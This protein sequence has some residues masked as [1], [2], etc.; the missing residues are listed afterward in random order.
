MVR[1]PRVVPLFVALP[2]EDF[3]AVERLT[4]P[5]P[6][7]LMEGDVGRAGGEAGVEGVWLRGV[8]VRWPS[9]R[10]R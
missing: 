2:V 4:L 5:V 8:A 3:L 9:L 7:T 10:R 1:L 6:P